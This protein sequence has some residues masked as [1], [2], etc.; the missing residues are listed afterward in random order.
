MRL[1][2]EA[3]RRPEL[4][5]AMSDLLLDEP[6]EMPFDARR[7]IADTLA[8][9]GTPR[10]QEALAAAILHDDLLELAAVDEYLSVLIAVYYV[11]SP[12][13]HLFD[14][15]ASVIPELAGRAHDQA[16]MSIGALGRAAGPTSEL[17]ERARS[18]LDAEAAAVFD[19]DDALEARR[20]ELLSDARNQWDGFTAQEQMSWLHSVHGWRVHEGAEAWEHASP[21]DRDRW[22]NTT[23]WA[24][25][26]ELDG[27]GLASDH[28][29]HGRVLR[30]H[31]AI[32]DAER[33]GS[34]VYH[35]R[36]GAT[37]SEASLQHQVCG[38]YTRA[39]SHACR[40]PHRGMRCTWRTW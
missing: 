21:L 24:I 23:L 16:L 39:R 28:A 26:H 2:R 32:A 35:T 25:A 33:A 6:L 18:I 34:P 15:V 29:T 11:R 3:R 38:A 19:T 5:A 17:G 20:R 31:Q 14:A 4:V 22:T 1:A 12:T 37:V 7:V 9:V 36:H 8:V 13:T 10:A 30:R 40:A 27:A